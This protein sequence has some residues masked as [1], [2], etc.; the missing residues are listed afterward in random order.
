ME[1]RLTKGGI[2][3]FD[4]A[5]VSATMSSQLLLGSTRVQRE[6]EGTVSVR[7]AIGLVVD[8]PERAVCK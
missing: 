5:P 1:T 8:H 2:G 7:R 4:G 6:L 3:G